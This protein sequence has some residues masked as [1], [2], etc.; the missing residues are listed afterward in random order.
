MTMQCER[1]QQPQ[2]QTRL[3]TIALDGAAPTPAQFTLC[4]SCAAIGA[5]LEPIEGITDFLNATPTVP[6]TDE[7]DR[8]PVSSPTNGSTRLR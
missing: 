6:P 7:S 1:C 8:V 2:A 3:L 4:R 5:N